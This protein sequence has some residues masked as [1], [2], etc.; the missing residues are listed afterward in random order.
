MK[1]IF[2]IMPSLGGGG[3]ERVI[4]TIL[5]NLN[6]EKFKPHLII[7]KK[8]G[9]N[10][11]INNLKGDISVH[12]L[13]IKLPIKISFLT[14]IYKTAKICWK[15]KPDTLFFGSGQINVL[16]SPFLFLFPQKTQ[17]IARESNLPTYFEKYFILKCFYKL[18]YKNYDRIIVQSNDMQNDLSDNFNI[19]TSKLVKINNPVDVSYIQ[20]SLHKPT[21]RLLAKSTLNLLAA[22]RLTQQKGFDLLIESLSSITSLNF[23]LTILGDGQEKET[24]KQLCKLHKLDDKISFAGNVINPYLYMKEADIFILSSRFEGFPNVVLESLTCG[25]PVLSNNCLGGINEIIISGVNGEIYSFDK[26]NDFNQKL[27]LIIKTK[28]SSEKITNDT[29]KKYGVQHKILEFEQILT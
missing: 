15:L 11:F 4:S 20:S 8:V 29:I 13:N 18:F 25:T 21:S 3:G 19:P 28:Y 6:R 1:T 23:H 17:K 12:Y 14:A 27:N 5:N 16:F 24:L 22:G 2:F 10:E 7:L 9:A 26:K